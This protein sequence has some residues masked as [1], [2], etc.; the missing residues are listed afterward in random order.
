[1]IVAHLIG[2]NEIEGISKGV[3]I[4]NGKQLETSYEDLVAVCGNISLGDLDTTKDEVYIRRDYIRLVEDF[5]DELGEDF[6]DDNHLVEE[7][8]YSHYKVDFEKR[9]LTLTIDTYN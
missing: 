7:I 6:V 8:C 5:D 3:V 2:G 1:M 9:T 4:I